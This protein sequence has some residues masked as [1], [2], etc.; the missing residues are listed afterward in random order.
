MKTQVDRLIERLEGSP[1]E[2]PSLAELTATVDEAMGERLEAEQRAKRGVEG[3]DVT[4]SRVH[5]VD[6]ERGPL[7]VDYRDGMKQKFVLHDSVSLTIVP[8]PR[9]EGATTPPVFALIFEQDEAGGHTVEWPNEVRW[10]QSTYEISERA[11]DAGADDDHPYEGEYKTRRATPGEHAQAIAVRADPRWSTLF[12]VACMP[13][14][15]YASE[16]LHFEP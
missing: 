6:G 10:P 14:G 3:R 2:D 12:S 16:P 1:E 4:A 15:L 5:T 9:L 11:D 8:P 7:V 13:G